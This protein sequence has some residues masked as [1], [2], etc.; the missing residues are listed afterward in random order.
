MVGNLRGRPLLV[1]TLF[2]IIFVIATNIFA[3]SHKNNIPRVNL[4]ERLFDNFHIVQPGLLYRSAQ[5]SYR[6]LMHYIKKFKIKTIINLRGKN[7]HTEW[8][9]QEK[10]C[11]QKFDI[12][13][14]NIASSALRPSTKHEICQLLALYDH[15][16]KPILIHC[17]SGS[18]RTGEAAAIWILDKQNKNKKQALKQLSWW[19]G[20][21]KTRRPYKSQFI[22]AWQGRDWLTHSYHHTFLT[23][24]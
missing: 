6:K 13:F 24:K 19:Y 16:P 15:A 21:L 23:R 22:K 17:Y 3:S 14:F 9:Q 10:K 18:D 8:W 20:H 12:Q 11:A 4:W 2:Y 1:G 7:K 5:L